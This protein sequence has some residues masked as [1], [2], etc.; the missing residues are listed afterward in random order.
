MNKNSFLI[1]LKKLFIISLL[2]CFFHIGASAQ[3]VYTAIRSKAVSIVE[4]P[5][6]DGLLKELN[7]FKIDALDYMAM[8]MK[9]VM[10]DTTAVFLDQ[11]AYGMNG[12]LNLYIKT[13]LDYQKEPPAFQVKII[14]LFM[15]A[16]FSNPLF[17][18]PD[19]ELVLSY[20]ADGKS[21]TR[22]SLD[23]DWLIAY[24]AAKTELGKIK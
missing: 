1:S 2:A 12:F 9:E 24:M 20:F 21:M 14:K 3:E 19:K 7:Q 6:S 8:K 11:E 4:N 17:N 15:D 22:F 10:P 5:Q 16:S 23:T 13:I 18:D